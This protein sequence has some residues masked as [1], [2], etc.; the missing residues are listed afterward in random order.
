MT[1]A[2]CVSSTYKPVSGTVEANVREYTASNFET[3]VLESDQPVLVSFSAGWCRSARALDRTLGE[4]GDRLG[5]RLAVGRVDVEEQAVLPPRYGVRGLPT[6]ML[7]KS[8]E[9]VAT[10]LG[11]VS[12]RRLDEWVETLL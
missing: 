11:A 4:L 12:P 7:F 5:D 8:G 10:K 1:R 2:C 6:L 9:I 3:E